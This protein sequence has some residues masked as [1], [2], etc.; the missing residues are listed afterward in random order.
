MYCAHVIRSLLT[1]IE[2]ELKKLVNVELSFRLPLD[3]Q[4][5][6]KI[7]QLNYIILLCEL[8]NLRFGF[9]SP[10]STYCLEL[11]SKNNLKYVQNSIRAQCCFFFF[12]SFRN[13]TERCFCS[14]WYA[15]IQYGFIFM[16]L[17]I[18]TEV[19]L[20]HRCA[21]CEINSLTLLYASLHSS[22]EIETLKNSYDSVC[23]ATYTPNYALC[24]TVHCLSREHTVLSRVPE[25]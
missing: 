10:I 23:S 25:F 4:F 19:D 11:M 24:Y 3:N 18:K 13:G 2:F 16:K 6:D 12:Y 5:Y 9:R 17:N 15:I 22:K 1:S 21:E 14:D 7:C 20:Q 8:I